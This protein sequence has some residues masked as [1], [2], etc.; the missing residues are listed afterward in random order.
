MAGGCGSGKWR[1]GDVYKCS[2]ATSSCS[3]EQ[4]VG[5][6]GPRGVLIHFLLSGYPLPLVTSLARHSWYFWTVL[7]LASKE[8]GLLMGINRGDYLLEL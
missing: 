5:K 7:F 8:A 4:L 1:E 2:L 3:S 6:V